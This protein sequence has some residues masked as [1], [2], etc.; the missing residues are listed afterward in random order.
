MQEEVKRLIQLV[1]KNDILS[2]LRV[3]FRPHVDSIFVFIDGVKCGRISKIKCIGETD[4]ALF[5]TL[6]QVIVMG[7]VDKLWHWNDLLETT[8]SL[9]LPAQRLKE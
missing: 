9:A 4:K 8:K 7:I 3:D 6:R 2:C 5:A 1:Q